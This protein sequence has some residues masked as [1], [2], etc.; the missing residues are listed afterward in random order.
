MFVL[1]SSWLPTV[2]ALVAFLLALYYKRTSIRDTDIVAFALVA[3]V[4]FFLLTGALNAVHLPN[5][6]LHLF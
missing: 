6:A 1:S 5:F 3:A 2:V 4:V